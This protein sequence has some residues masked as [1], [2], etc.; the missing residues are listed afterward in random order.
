MLR[1]EAAVL[2]KAYE[3][4]EGA[5]GDP[6]AIATA[7]PLACDLLGA[8]QPR[9]QRRSQACQQLVIVTFP[10]PVTVIG[11]VVTNTPQVEVNP[12]DIGEFVGLR[13]VILESDAT[14]S[15]LQHVGLSVKVNGDFPLF[16]TG[17]TETF[18]PLTFVSQN[19][20]GQPGGT[21]TAIEIDNQVNPADRWFVECTSFDGSGAP[22]ATYTPILGFLFEKDLGISDSALKT[23]LGR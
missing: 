6:R 21:G 17:K 15:L 12:P 1:S 16:T 10:T 18:S 19:P 13:A 11:G 2:D 4:L 22:D 20:L 5:I 23:L 14:D 7:L 8:M 9:W 3:L